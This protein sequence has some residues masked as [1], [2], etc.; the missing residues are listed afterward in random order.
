M[1]ADPFYA[2][3]DLFAFCACAENQFLNL[4][5]AKFDAEAPNQDDENYMQQS[6]RNLR[7]NK[8]ILHVHIEQLH[9]TIS[10]IRRRGSPRW[11]RAT[12][13]NTHGRKLSS[14]SSIN[15]AHE[16]SLS[17]GLSFPASIRSIDERASQLGAASKNDPAQQAAL[18]DAA[19]SS[20]LEDYQ[21]LLHR[22]NSLS[23]LYSESIDDIRTSAMLVESRKAIVQAEGVAR[24]TLLAFFFLPLSFTTSL[25]G[26]N[27][28]ELGDQLSIWTWAVVAVPVFGFS[29]ILCYWRELSKTLRKLQKS[30]T[31]V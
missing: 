15:P 23:R 30:S 31:D 4:L 19:A 14:P 12:A 18:A 16:P 22:A 7:Y 20:L 11:P 27:F 26:M 6:L 29:V 9:N 21:A 10:C 8:A 1:R 24:L 3:H 17:R 28:K 5:K 2:M 13:Q 25:F